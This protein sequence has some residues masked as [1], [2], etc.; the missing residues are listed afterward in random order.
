MIRFIKQ[1]ILKARRISA[2]KA[3]ILFLLTI[4][5]ILKTAAV[6]FWDI[7]AAALL[8]EKDRI[9]ALGMDLILAGILIGL[10]GFRIWRLDRQKG[11]GAVGLCAGCVLCMSLALLLMAQ[12]G[13]DWMADILFLM[14]YPLWLILTTAYWAVVRRFVAV[15]FDSL[16]FLGLFCC[17]L[18]GFGLA[19]LTA[20]VSAAAP[21]GLM[22]AALF[23]V[24]A[25]TL[26]LRTVFDLAPQPAEA[27]VRKTDGIQD[28][29][30]RPL[31]WDIFILFFLGS[32]TRILGEIVLYLKLVETGVQPIT[33]LGLIWLLFGGMGCLMVLV[34]YRTRYIYTTLSG[35]MIFGCSIILTGVAAMGRHSG[36]VA[37]GYLMMLLLAHFYLAGYLQILPRVLSNGVGTRLKKRVFTGVMPLGF[38]FC[39]SLALNA[40]PPV[41]NKILVSLG[42]IL[43]LVTIRSAV[44]YAQ[45]IRRMMETRFWCRGPIM[46]PFPKMVTHLI[47]LLKSRQADEVIYA[48]RMLK[49]ANHPAGES[50]LVMALKH[51]KKEVRL[52]ALMRM[53]YLYRLADYQPQYRK[54]LQK[55]P[56]NSVRNQALTNLI[57]S[58]PFPKKYEKY[59][60]DRLLKAGA[61]GGFLARDGIKNPS[62][63]EALERLARSKMPRDNIAAL[64]LMASY[65]D[66]C[67]TPWVERFLK[68]PNLALVR[69]AL[70][71]AGSLKDPQLLPR[72]FRALDD[73]RLQEYALNALKMYG[74][75][76]FPPIERLIVREQT[77]MT[78]R[79]QMILFLGTLSSG[80]GK[81][82]LLRSLTIE[83][84]KLR[85]T[86]IQNILDSG[87]VW[88]QSEKRNI[89]KACLKKDIG[90]ISWLIRL[91]ENLMNAPT[92]E[93]EEAIGF[94]LRAIQEDIDDT[95]ELI[96]YQMLLLENNALFGRAVRVL[97]SDS[98]E[99]YLPAMGVVQDLIPGRLYQK[100]KPVLLLPL[101]QKHKATL[102]GLTPE[103]VVEQLSDVITQPPIVLNHWIRATALYALRRLGLA[104]G[105]RAA[106]TALA[107]PHP[108]VL[109]AAIWTLVRLQPDKEA[110]HRQLLTIPTSRLSSLS[111]DRLLDS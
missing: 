35:M 59:L 96:L 12:T 22:I 77:P 106:E 38:I 26:V 66:K 41:L 83:N 18:I 56:E 5:V 105:I 43:I 84:Q 49:V 72:I 100:I 91:R 9:F 3:R 87:I 82:I 32:S 80:E 10:I 67:W 34:L 70:L 108:I 27:F 102:S 73:V 104:S 111:L 68:K 107:D 14:K 19:G 20:V 69:Q 90:R 99:L 29:F 65:P 16:K 53:R 6:V 64:S 24:V 37:S 92:H 103:Q 89:L 39:G 48:L 54:L 58:D 98:Y 13:A 78:L 93:S 62:V 28:V 94:F 31:L 36:P 1:A 76:A 110:L 7:G 86:I 21:D 75:A 46:L 63:V 45:V 88:I 60:S 40:Q 11:R 109:E 57:L 85:K 33:V 79:K 97:L 15:R 23:S 52:Y 30:E 74:K 81:Q 51:P 2:D 50:A 42:C 44:L 71:A 25:L 17:E 95:R 55:D 61:V 101:A 47:R 8:I 4:G